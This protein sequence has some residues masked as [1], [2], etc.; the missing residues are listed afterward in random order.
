MNDAL[1]IDAVRTPI[2]RYAGALSSV[3]ADDLG[4]VPLRELLRRHPNVDWSTV[5][6][7]IYGGAQALLAVVGAGQFDGKAPDLGDC[8]EHA[9]MAFLGAVTQAFHPFTGA[10]QVIGDFLDGLGGDP[11]DAFVAGLA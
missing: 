1:I 5:D 3:R 6:D 4:A 7:V 10:A 9:R 2:G 8:R 11:G